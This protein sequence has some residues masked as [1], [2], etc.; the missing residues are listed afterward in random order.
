MLCDLDQV[1]AVRFIL[2]QPSPVWLHFTIEE[3]QIFPPGQKVRRCLP[4]QARAGGLRG[5]EGFQ[6]PPEDTG[7]WV[8]VL[9]PC[10]GTWG[11][12]VHWGPGKGLLTLFGGGCLS[13]GME[14]EVTA[15]NHGLQPPLQTQNSL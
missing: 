15:T 7:L 4:C 14:L 2:R 11:P 5:S 6:L 12:R 3:L 8:P 9:V 1:T 13:S 10:W